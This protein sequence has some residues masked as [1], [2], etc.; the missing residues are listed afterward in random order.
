MLPA[1]DRVV[2]PDGV[3]TREL[4]DE[5]ILLNLD[6]ESYFGLDTIGAAMWNALVSTDSVGNAAVLLT[7]EFD[8]ERDRLE[9]DLASLIA[10]LVDRGLLELRHP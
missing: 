1:T 4:D 3:L 8:V 5:M 9:A 10:S 6:S 2:V 7:E